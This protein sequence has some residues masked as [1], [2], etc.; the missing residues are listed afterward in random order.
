MKFN[1]ESPIFQFLGTMADHV[2]LNFLFLITCIP[3]VTIGA[4]SSALYTIT[5]RDAREEHGYLIGPYFN[6][7]RENLKKA[8]LYF[9]YIL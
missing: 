4:A 3:L 1:T 2:L 6:A 5:L 7:F 9:F 8:L